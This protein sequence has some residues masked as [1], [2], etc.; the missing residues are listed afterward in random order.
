L[1]QF[2]SLGRPDY[3][4]AFPTTDAAFLQN[5]SMHGKVKQQICHTKMNMKS[6]HELPSIENKIIPTYSNCMYGSIATPHVFT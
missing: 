4:T 1:D 2:A 3:L 6:S 5:A